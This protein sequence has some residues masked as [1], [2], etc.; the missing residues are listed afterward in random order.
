ML[1]SEY[2]E[3]GAMISRL[4]F[5]GGMF[6]IKP[7][8]AEK[9]VSP[10]T[11]DAAVQAI[12]D[13]KAINRPGGVFKI[14]NLVANCGMVMEAETRIEATGN[15]EKIEKAQKKK[16]NA[17]KDSDDGVIHFGIWVGAG[18]KVDTNIGNPK[19]GKEASVDIV[20]VLFPCI[21]PGA[22]GKDYN[23]MLACEKWLSDLAGGTTWVD[24]MKSYEAKMQDNAPVPTS[25][26]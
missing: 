26:F 2:E 5:N 14:G 8:V 10:E 13:N 18:M 3:S 16:D 4:G 22:K 19:L 9:I 15:L 11:D 12:I 20:K 25:L 17:E 24:E 7:R 23:K 21:D 1:V 6:D